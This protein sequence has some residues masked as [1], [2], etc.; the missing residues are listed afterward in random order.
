MILGK[1][2][3]NIFLY[4]YKSYLEKTNYF[5]HKSSEIKCVARASTKL[6][7]SKLDT[8]PNNRKMV[9]KRNDQIKSIHLLSLSYITT[10]TQT[11]RSLF[12]SQSV[13]LSVCL[14]VCQCVFLCLLGCVHNIRLAEILIFPPDD[15]ICQFLSFS[16]FLILCEFLF[17]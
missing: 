2:S 7:F 9:E 17:L 11:Y 15:K 16:L 1:L 12:E 5:Q 4:F 14:S 13:C 6:I 8:R 3:N 10:N